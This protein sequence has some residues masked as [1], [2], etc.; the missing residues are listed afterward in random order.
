[1]SKT[2]WRISVIAVLSMRALLFG[3]ARYGRLDYLFHDGGQRFPGNL[4]GQRPEMP[5]GRIALD[6]GMEDVEFERKMGEDMADLPG[7]PPIGGKR[8]GVRRR[9]AIHPGGPRGGQH[10]GH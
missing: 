9:R 10:Y 3:R 4:V 5:V 7:A 1:M 2:I 6:A 8:R